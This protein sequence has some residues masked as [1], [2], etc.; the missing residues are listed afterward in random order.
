MKDLAVINIK[1]ILRTNGTTQ[2]FV[3]EKAGFTERSFSDLL[4]G[5]KVFRSEYV[6]KICKSL[7]CQPNDLYIPQW[8]KCH[9]IHAQ[10]K[11]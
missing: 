9:H 6:P 8:M 5:R 4:N 11:L 3:A 7:D 2:K 10:N 1:R